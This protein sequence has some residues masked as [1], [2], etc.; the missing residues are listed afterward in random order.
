MTLPLGL[1]VMRGYL[2]VGNVAAIMA[3][4]SM[5]ILPVLLV[6]LLA[7]RYLIEGITLT[8]IKG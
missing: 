4:V 2:G 5:G 7:Q 1:T 8:G 3:G 6:F